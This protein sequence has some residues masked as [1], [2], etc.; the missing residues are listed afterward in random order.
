MVSSHN[1][2]RPLLTKAWQRWSDSRGTRVLWVSALS[3]PSRLSSDGRIPHPQLHSLPPLRSF[4]LRKC[5]A[6]GMTF[7]LAAS[8]LGTIKVR[9]RPRWTVAMHCLVHTVRIRLSYWLESLSL[10]FSHL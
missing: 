1:E 3:Q 2:K 4:F 9:S 5:R 7:L 6:R 10:S 8:A